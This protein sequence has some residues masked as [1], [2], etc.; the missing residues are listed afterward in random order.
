MVDSINTLNRRRYDSVVAKR[1]ADSARTGSPPMMTT[2]SM[3]DGVEVQRQIPARPPEMIPPVS[4][5]DIP[6]FFPPI[7][8]G[9]VLADADN[10]VW[11]RHRPAPADPVGTTI[12]DI[13]DRTGTLVDRVIISASQPLVAFAPGGHVFTTMSDAGKV[14]LV[15]RRVK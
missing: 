11:I 4:A 2:S 14:T 5:A 7:T 8:A 12:W 1:A 3:V 13:V 15:K 6:D 9:G 10:R